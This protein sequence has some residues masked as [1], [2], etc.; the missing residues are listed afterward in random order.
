MLQWSPNTRELLYFQL[1]LFS[2]HNI[3]AHR[4]QDEQTGK[5]FHAM[6]A[7]IHDLRARCDGYHH[8]FEEAQ[9]KLQRLRELYTLQVLPKVKE[10]VGSKHAAQ[11]AAATS[12]KAV[13]ARVRSKTAKVAPTQQRTRETSH[14]PTGAAN[15]KA[16]KPK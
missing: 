2:A 16:V 12:A 11:P 13:D 6:Q 3:S 8:A 5:A 1:N 10:E 14:S 9:K 7:E 4:I 15:R